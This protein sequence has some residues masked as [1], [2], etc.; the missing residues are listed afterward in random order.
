MEKNIQDEVL[1][2]EAQASEVIPEKEP[3]EDVVDGAEAPA[4][5][6]APEQTENTCVPCVGKGRLSDTE[7]CSTCEGTGK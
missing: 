4:D 6:V 3:S 2:S 1:A 5:D 7:I